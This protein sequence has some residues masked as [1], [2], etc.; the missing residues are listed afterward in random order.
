MTDGRLLRGAA[1]RRAVLRRAVDIA[2]VEGLDALSIGRLATELEL[3]KSGVFALFGSKEKLQLAAVRAAGEIFTDQVIAPASG[4]QAGLP[5]LW[6]LC[7]CWLD[8][9]R[10][11]VF[12]GGCFFFQTAAEFD[13]RSGRVHDAIAESHRRW[14]ERLTDVTVEA[15]KLGH[16]DS[17]IEV[18]QLVFEIDALARAANADSVLHGGKA[19]YHLARGSILTRLRAAAAAP[20]TL[21]AS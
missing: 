3:S 8:Y 12:P 17:G 9:S 1:T 18:A 11:R 2:S 14:R 15:T 19:A 5:R 10:R 7:E 4:A 20:E 6:K 21:P 13:A 16:L